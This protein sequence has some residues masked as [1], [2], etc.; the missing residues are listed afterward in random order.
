MKKIG[1]ARVS[2]NEQN[3]DLQINALKENGC[4]EIYTEK[5]SGRKTRPILNGL[6]KKL[7][8][9]DTL[10]VWKIDRLGRNMLGIINTFE[11]LKEKKITVISLNEGIDSSKVTGKVYMWQCAIY[12]EIEVDNNRARTIAGLQAAKARG[13]KLGRR[14]GLSQKAMEKAE[15]TYSLYNKGEKISIICEKAGICKATM[16]KYLRTKGTHFRK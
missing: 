6:L 10:V 5:E 4:T 16:Y 11:A 12:A 9:N 2:K 14:K 15:L 3:L 13:V 7:K 8:A 1:Y